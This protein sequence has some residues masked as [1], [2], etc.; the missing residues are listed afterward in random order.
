LITSLLVL[1]GFAFLAGF[2]DSI[3]GGGGLIQLPAL[4]IVF[5]GQVDAG[6][7]QLATLWGTNKLSSIAGTSLAMTQFVRRVEVQWRSMIP[8]AIMAFVLSYCG[9]ML[10]SQIDS[11]VLRPLVLVLLIAV[12]I[13]TAWKK[14]FGS[15]HA[16]KL[17]QRQQTFY[18]MLVCGAIGFYDGFFGPGT[19]SFLIFAFIGIFGFSFLTASASAKI[20]NFSTNLASV[21]FF[22][23]TGKILYHYALPMAV[24][25]I[26]GSY[27]GSHLAL[28]K[29][30]QFIRIFFLVVVSAIIARFAYDWWISV[31]VERVR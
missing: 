8:A 21:L 15:L 3:V 28:K 5:K 30:S 18:G 27:L 19:G 22:A 9:S 24:C 23:S 20:I 10:V 31:P 16:P 13:Y 14:D 6:E 2:L 25:N 4:L 1:C 7:I 17:T 11:K 29:G 26:A 12:F